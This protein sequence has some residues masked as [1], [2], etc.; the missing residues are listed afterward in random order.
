MDEQKN[1]QEQLE[2]IQ[3]VPAPAEEIPEQIPAAE[4]VED[5]TPSETAEEAVTEETAEEK[6]AE[7]AKKATPGKIAL[8]VGA[9]VVLAA[10]LILIGCRKNNPQKL[11]KMMNYKRKL[12][13]L[14]I[15]LVRQS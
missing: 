8:A 12:M 7:P 4:A 10:V 1:N 14:I 3:E 5:Q 15:N 11:W 13:I 9:V 2:E 6:T